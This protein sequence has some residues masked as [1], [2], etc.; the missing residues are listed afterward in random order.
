MGLLR[1]LFATAIASVHLDLRDCRIK[2]EVLKGGQV[3]FEE[4]K[5]LRS[6]PN[7]LPIEAA[8]YLSRMRRRY[9]FTYI[10]TISQTIY[11][12]AFS[13][14]GDSECSRFGVNPAGVRRVIVGK[15]WTAF[16]DKG[17]IIEER[18][19]FSKAPSLDFLYSPFLILYNSIRSRLDNSKK[20]Y[21]LQQQSTITMMI[22]DTSKLYYGCIQPLE[23][24]NS[25]GLEDE[26]E[27]NSI[28]AIQE[29]GLEEIGE[30]DNLDEIEGPQEF[31]DT[32]QDM[33]INSLEQGK[34]SL[35]DFSRAVSIVNSIKQS[36]NEF[37]NNDMY[38]SDFVSEIV[39]VDPLQMS[40][41][42]I[43]YIKT[44]LMID[45]SIISIDMCDVISEIVRRDL[46]EV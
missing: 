3:V 40:Q 15:Q 44:N 5:T 19:N 42:A 20:L 28:E 32:S 4:I 1:S 34:K 35:E 46:A 31:Q 29:E 10:A 26:L 7:E 22:M 27:D 2:F 30:I 16:I 12:G 8:H 9:P 33:E 36:L 21:L 17:A 41:K 14:I 6:S 38:E 13:A 11:Q 18:N 23:A 43:S 24:V 25:A 37:Y 45:L 39:C